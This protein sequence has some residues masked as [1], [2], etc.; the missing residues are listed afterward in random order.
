M[1][2]VGSVI[3]KVRAALRG[4]RTRKSKLLS[5][6]AASSQRSTLAPCHTATS[7]CRRARRARFTGGRALRARGG[8]QAR[9]SRAGGAFGAAG[10]RGPSGPSGF[11]PSFTRKIFMFLSEPLPPLEGHRKRTPFR[12]TSRRSPPQ[13]GQG[14]TPAQESL[15]KVAHSGRHPPRKASGWYPVRKASRRCPPQEG[16]HPPQE[17]R[18]ATGRLEGL[19]K[20]S[21]RYPT[22]EGV[23]KA[24]PPRKAQEGTPPGRSQEGIPS[25][26]PQE[27]DPLRQAPRRHPLREASRRYPSLLEDIR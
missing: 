5:R 18:K 13:E 15:R 2:F 4:R 21:G 26:R 25:R 16:W 11:V 10:P 9:A 17:G 3:K 19:R 6:S 20:A 12:K 7:Y 24:P 23:R 14:G 1:W 22:Q 8:R 27:V